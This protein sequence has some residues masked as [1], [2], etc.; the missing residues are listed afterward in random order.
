MSTLVTFPGLGLEMTVSRVAFSLFG[1]EIYWYGLIIALGQ[2]AG[3][4]IARTAL[5]TERVSKIS[6]RLIAAMEFRLTVIGWF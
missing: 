3:I 5:G 6:L 2:M 4:A 1:V